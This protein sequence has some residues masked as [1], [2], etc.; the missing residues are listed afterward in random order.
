MRTRMLIINDLRKIAQVCANYGLLDE[1]QLVGLLYA[2][3]NV[4][5]AKKSTP[6]TP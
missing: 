5:Q 6:Y 4:D 1:E 3:T 2:P